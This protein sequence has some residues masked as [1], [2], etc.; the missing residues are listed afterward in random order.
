MSALG[1]RK[2]QGVRGVMLLLDRNTH[3]FLLE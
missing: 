2:D 1:S 3:A